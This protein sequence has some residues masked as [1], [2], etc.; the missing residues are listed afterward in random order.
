M[1]HM[2]VKAPSNIKSIESGNKQLNKL[3][4][5]TGV[6]S[7]ISINDNESKWFPEKEIIRIVI[8]TWGFLS[9]G[10]QKKTDELM[11]KLLTTKDYANVH[12]IAII[13]WGFF[14]RFREK[15]IAAKGEGLALLMLD[16]AIAERL[17]IFC[18]PGN[19]LDFM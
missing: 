17:A 19:L 4:K 8:T 9:N 16:K 6:K 13:G 3:T 1:L 14:L 11:K 12:A 10:D 5:E 18:S 15:F 7:V 2:E